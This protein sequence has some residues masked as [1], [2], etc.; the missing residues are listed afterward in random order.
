M[1][2]MY[3]AINGTLPMGEIHGKSTKNGIFPGEMVQMWQTCFFCEQVW[4]NVSISH[5]QTAKRVNLPLGVSDIRVILKLPRFMHFPS[6]AFKVLFN[7]ALQGP[8]LM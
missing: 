8:E 5:A 7:S 1:G 3:N 4:P 6:W 2:L